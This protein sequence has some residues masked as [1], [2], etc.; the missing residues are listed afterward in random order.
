MWQLAKQNGVTL[1]SYIYSAL[2]DATT[3]NDVTSAHP[4]VAEALGDLYRHLAT[5]DVLVMSNGGKD[6]DAYLLQ[7][8]RLAGVD[9]RVVNLGALA[10]GYMS[11]LFSA[12]T[13]LI[14]P[15]QY[16]AHKPAVLR[17]AG[18][19]PIKVCHPVMDASRV[20]EAARSCCPPSEQKTFDGPTR[21]GT[22]PCG[23][24]KGPFVDDGKGGNVGATADHDGELRPARFVMVGR[25]SPEKTPS[26]FVRAVAVL[27]RRWVA[28]GGRERRAEGVVVGKGPLLKHME[29][30]ARDL[31]ASVRFPGFLSVDAVP[32]EVQQ[33][34]A[35]VLP[36]TGLETFGMVGPEAMLLGV[37]VVTFGFGGSGELVR[38]MENGILVAEPTPRALANALEM[39]VRD[40]VL[41]NRLGEQARLDALKALSLPEMVACHTDE[42][43]RLTNKKRK[44]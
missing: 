23:S 21:V 38:H 40:P 25:I 12:A 7:V 10:G 26:V 44:K 14:G 20:L 27:Q 43:A 34:T 3:W 19:L 41:R 6:D 16:V 11:P 37:P 5:S 2:V 13:A 1:S 15:S 31:N 30:L 36:S 42:I 22:I 9:T 24:P 33:A 39:L 4:E 28:G 18:D 29:G 32:C 35:L 17:N 8:A